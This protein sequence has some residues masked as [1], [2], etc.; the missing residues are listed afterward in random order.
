M[1]QGNGQRTRLPKGQ[2]RKQ[3]N[4]PS[5]QRRRAARRAAQIQTTASA[6]QAAWLQTGQP[7]VTERL[8][9]ELEHLYD[10]HRDAQADTL[11]DPY[12]GWTW[13]PR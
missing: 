6:R 5:R 13:T 4:T 7:N 8:T 10:E 9:R 2:A 3:K 12:R 11:T 1:D